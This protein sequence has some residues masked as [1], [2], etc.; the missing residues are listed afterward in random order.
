MDLAGKR[1]VLV[2][3]LPPPAGGMANQTLQLAE[4]LREEG[5]V[6]ELVQTN[7]AYRPAWVATL[8]GVRAAFRLVPY[9]AR[10][11]HAAGRADVMHVMAN[12]GWSW[13][14]FAAPAVWVA[15]L[16]AVPVL[17]NYRGGEAA[18]FLSR[19]AGWV[20]PTINHAAAVL[21][22]SG[23]LHEIFARYGVD[24]R[25]VPNVVNLSRFKAIDGAR[26]FDQ[27]PH[28]V[29]ARNLEPIYGI[30]DAIRAFSRIC[31]EFPLARLSVAG[32]GP[33]ERELVG[34]VDALQLADRVRFTGR[35]DRDQMA[36]LYR[37]AD[38]VLNPA[39]VDNMPNSVLEALACGVPVVSTAVG[40]VPYIV[41]DGRS[42]LL[43]PQEDPA[44]MAEAALR[45]LRSAE[46]RQALIAEGSRVACRYT[47]AT[48]RQP[49]LAAYVA[50]L[51][52]DA[53]AVEAG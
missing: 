50:A 18:D 19:S 11:W 3:P 49:L 52:G 46:L 8:R 53:A 22:P 36:G 44:A 43:V 13:H 42:A 39:R 4:L 48:V 28:V 47:W 40:G 26:S 30:P 24:T 17:V 23:F 5:L 20:R 31:A 6:V 12:S 7:G 21:V 9:L 14:L 16:R 2:G 35:L 10:L 41:E 32:S 29:V 27:A 34:L 15:C 45:V 33:Q 1:I 38:L 51:R 25:V 37:D